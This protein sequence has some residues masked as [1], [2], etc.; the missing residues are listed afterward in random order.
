M[1]SRLPQAL[2]KRICAAVCCKA[3][4]NGNSSAS[5]RFKRCS[6]TRRAERGPS[7]KTVRLEP[8]YDASIPE[9]Q[10]FL[11]ATPWGQ[12]EITVDNPAALEQLTF[13][14]TFYVDLTPAG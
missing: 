12:M 2:Q 9:D 13:G 5:R 7:P 14:K 1:T 4:T 3:S 11:K 10:R 6:T 8:R